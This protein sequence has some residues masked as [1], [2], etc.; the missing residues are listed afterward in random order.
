MILEAESNTTP[1]DVKRGPELFRVTPPGT[2][3][4]PRGSCEGCSLPIW[5]E[6]DYRMPGVRG[7]FCRISCVE[8]VLFGTGRCRW[9]GWKMDGPYTSVDSRL[10]SSDCSENY[11]AHV[12]GSRTAALG[13][14]RRLLVWLQSNQ[15]ETYRRLLGE[16]PPKGRLCQNPNCKRGERGRPASLAHLRQGSRFCSEE[17]RDRARRAREDHKDR[18]GRTVLTGTFQPS[19]RPILR[20]FSRGNLG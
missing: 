7:L 14:G 9:C 2:E 11:Y 15:P 8:T 18:S 10:C 12:L 17:C 6:G 19:G 4:Q 16:I 20:G 3:G 5:S 1:P 13:T